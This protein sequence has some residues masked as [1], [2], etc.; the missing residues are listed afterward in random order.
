MF[1]ERLSLTEEE[2]IIPSHPE[3][4]VAFGAAM[5]LEQ[6]F[7]EQEAVYEIPKLTRQLAKEQNEETGHIRFHCQTFLCI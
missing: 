3:L 6:M 5:S 4:M 2:T 7:A 1:A